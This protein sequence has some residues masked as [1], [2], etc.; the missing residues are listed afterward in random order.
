MLLTISMAMY[1]FLGVFM[2]NLYSNNALLRP[3]MAQVTNFS[4]KNSRKNI[5][6]TEKIL[7]SGHWEGTITRD[8][9]N[10]KRTVFTMSLDIT[11]GKNGISGVS[12]VGYT[13]GGQTYSAKMAFTGKRKKNYLQYVETNILSSDNIPNSEWCI[14]QVDLRIS[15]Q[16][17]KAT[18]EGY[19]EGITSFGP[20][21]PGRI[22]LQKAVPRV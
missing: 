15:M 18:L 19:W 1:S 8:E 21:Q 16:D 14:K 11:E 22:F 7:L 12:I 10:A 9:G 3:N 2:S 17:G 4:D 5:F 6:S 20:C 13:E